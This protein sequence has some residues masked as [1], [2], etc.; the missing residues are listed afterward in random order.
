MNPCD[1]CP[2]LAWS[3]LSWDHAA[4][5]RGWHGTH[6]RSHLRPALW[7]AAAH[8]HA[9]V[10]TAPSTQLR[11]MPVTCEINEFAITALYLRTYLPKVEQF[12]I[13][14][15]PIRDY[16]ICKPEDL[17]N[18]AK[19]DRILQQIKKDPLRVSN[20]KKAPLD[21]AFRLFL[22]YLTA[23]RYRY[24]SDEGV[25]KFDPDGGGPAA[26]KKRYDEIIAAQVGG[27][28]NLNI[29]FH[30]TAPIGNC[31][32][33]ARALATLFLFLGWTQ[34]EIKLALLRPTGGTNDDH[35]V[36]THQ[37]AAAGHSTQF[38]RE[39]S[40]NYVSNVLEISDSTKGS[41]AL[42][43]VDPDTIDTPFQNH[44]VVRACGRLWDGNY[45]CTYSKPD[46]LFE[47]W[48]YRGRVKY[49]GGPPN[50]S[51]AFQ[52]PNQE[53]CL[54]MLPEALQLSHGR[55]ITK[56]Q[57]NYLLTPQATSDSSVSIQTTAGNI[58]LPRKTA[59]LYGWCVPDA[60]VSRKA[61]LMQA[62][63]AYE[64]ST[65]F[66]R[67]PSESSKASLRK[68]RKFC[69][70]ERIESRTVADRLYGNTDWNKVT[71]WSDGEAPDRVYELLGLNLNTKA[72][73][74]PPVGKRLWEELCNA[75]EVPDWLTSTIPRPGTE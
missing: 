67:L 26:N 37:A 58:S 4:T 64:A 68:I 65:S 21:E 15:H 59:R 17:K 1:L 22:N 24:I 47:H 40:S 54:I 71:K 13:G 6:T 46:D 50:G 35:M 72:V 73:T 43:A 75:F 11:S 41:V 8:C 33:T 51:V 62:V 39:S 74:R 2:T 42:A 16:L 28:S 36:Y 32:E 7:S 38:K 57:D 3:F 18:Q 63:R 29:F 10:T 70:E 9:G 30:P 56:A 14:K 12:V 19:T 55:P 20:K 23:K 25:H 61:L 53:R 31:V 52:S 34:N 66:W 60:D 45:A 49:F 48:T 44:W 69:G 5:V 27:L